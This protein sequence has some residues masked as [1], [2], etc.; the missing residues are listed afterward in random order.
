[1]SLTQ[2]S[3]TKPITWA[4]ASTRSV[5]VSGT[6]FAYRQLGADSG[7]PVIFLNHLAAEC[8]DLN[9]HRHYETLA[10][11]QPM[12]ARTRRSRC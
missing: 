12:C 7:V 9:R 4:N 6:K 1:M 2:H 8:A 11:C 3:Q 10:N 5:D